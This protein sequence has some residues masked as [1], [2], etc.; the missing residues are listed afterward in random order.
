MIPRPT[1]KKNMKTQNPNTT[2]I[3]YKPATRCGS[4][5]AVTTARSSTPP[6][7]ERGHQ[8]AEALAVALANGIFSPA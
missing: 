4:S 5:T 8:I 2:N 6:A 7:T 1:R 3:T